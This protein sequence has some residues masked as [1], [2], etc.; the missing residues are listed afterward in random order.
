MT[1]RTE[2]VI[3]LPAL[4]IWV[5]FILSVANLVDIG[6]TGVNIMDWVWDFLNGQWGSL[7]LAI[8]MVLLLIGGFC[9]PWIVRRWPKLRSRTATR[10]TALECQLE[11]TQAQ[12]CALKQLKASVNGLV[13]QVTAIDGRLK[14][15]EDKS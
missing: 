13:G 3:S 14:S 11:K 8:L 10:L 7:S 12:L 2:Q 15:L 4:P 5:V 1:E 9:S 6:F